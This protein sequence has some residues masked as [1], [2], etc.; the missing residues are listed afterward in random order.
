MQEL[1][2]T[3]QYLKSCSGKHY[4]CFDVNVYERIH[5]IHYVF[6]CGLLQYTCVHIQS[7]E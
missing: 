3:V 7:P 6:T 4:K 5:V 1:L 2:K